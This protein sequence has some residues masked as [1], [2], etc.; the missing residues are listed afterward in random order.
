MFDKFKKRNSSQNSA[1]ASDGVLRGAV[2][3]LIVG[4]G[5][6]GDKYAMTRHNIGFMTVS[7]LADRYGASL[8]RAKFQALCGD[9]VIG[10]KH[11]LLMLP[12]TYMNNSG[13][14]VR[15]AASFYNIA[16]EHI[17]VICDD[18]NL[19]AGKIRIRRAGSAG[20]HNGLKSI[21]Y[22]LNSEAFPR[23]RI[24][25]G[26]KPEQYDL[27]DWVLSVFPEQDRPLLREAAGHATDALPLL[28]EGEF[29]RAMCIYN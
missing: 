21:I 5:N 17:F 24:G 6:P 8:R 13:E 1:S 19:D 11:A 27:A 7:S 20:G 9:C 25:V 29:E 14:S 3:E 26:K 22:H 23:I 18:I 2:T 10:D 15:E 16:P 4:L 28:L 12:Q